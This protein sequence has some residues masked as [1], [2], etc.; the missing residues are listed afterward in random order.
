MDARQI[1]Q[2]RSHELMRGIRPE[3]TQQI[4]QTLTRDSVDTTRTWGGTEAGEH[5]KYDLR[6]LSQAVQDEVA[7]RGSAPIG[8]E[9]AALAAGAILTAPLS[10]VI[11]FGL[12]EG[13][14]STPMQQLASQVVDLVQNA[15]PELAELSKTVHGSVQ[16]QVP[17]AYVPVTMLL[18]GAELENEQRRLDEPGR[19]SSSGFLQLQL[20]KANG[21]IDEG[22]ARQM[23]L[24]Q[25][26]PEP[27]PWKARQHELRAG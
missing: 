21:R 27:T 22:L 17:S 9:Q 24:Q 18:A 25:Q 3:N 12:V 2:I 23:A 16:G 5:L 7:R 8:N 14:K 11:M 13:L 26:L 20:I 6:K 1:G 10:G 4:A 19:L 15:P